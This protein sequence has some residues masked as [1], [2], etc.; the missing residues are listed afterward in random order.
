M[1]SDAAGGARWVTTLDRLHIGGTARV[2]G[3][4]ME[5]DRGMHLMEMGLTP[6]TDV[7]LA[8][9]APLGDPIDVYVRGYHLSLRRSE[10]RL[11]SVLPDT[12]ES[13]A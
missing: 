9:V 3:V 12:R 2:T 7:V 13:A 1:I 8:R 4:A 11:V 6:G 10:A 5:G